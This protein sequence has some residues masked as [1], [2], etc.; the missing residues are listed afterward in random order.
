MVDFDER[1]LNTGIYKFLDFADGRHVKT[2]RMLAKSE[3]DETTLA[4]YLSK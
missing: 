3:T 1:A 2:V 4:V